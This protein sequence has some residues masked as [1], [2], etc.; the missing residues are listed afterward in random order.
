MT[1]MKKSTM[2]YIYSGLLF[3]LFFD[4][5][6][7]NSEQASNF[8]GNWIKPFIDEPKFSLVWSVLAIVAIVVLFKYILD[9]KEEEKKELEKT[10]ESEMGILIMAN[11]ELNS[12][13]LQDNLMSILNRFVQRYSYVNAAQWYQ[14]VENNHQGQ[15]KI[16][17][18][19]QYGAEAEEVNLNAIQ[20]LYY[21]CNISTLREFREVKEAYTNGDADPLVDFIIDVHNRIAHKSE[22]S[23][24]QEDAVLCSLMLLSFEIL[25]RD[26]GIVFEDFTESNVD[27]F[28]RLIDDNR[29]GIF[30]AALMED[31]Y[32]SFTHT[33]DNQKFN[34]Q[35]IGRL[36]K[37]GD[38]N[39]VFTIVLDSS[40]LDEPKYKEIMLNIAT[41]FESLLKDLE[42]MYN[43]SREG[44]G[45]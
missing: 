30:R 10:L 27:K 5:W 22:E 2:L 35:Y 4:L 12:Y 39:I 28:Q 32:Y 44:E 16:K 40:I 3:I 6:V 36:L 20:Q 42:K 7:E 9:A 29:T 8:F 18:N 37:I 26:F 21:Y 14:Y 45:D 11:K 13:R 33:R 38:Q 34:R 15:T 17:L 23:L 24:T 43:K 31:E 41:D 25:E 19:F 1:Q